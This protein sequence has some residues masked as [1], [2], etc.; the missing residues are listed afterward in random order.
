MALGGTGIAGMNG[1]VG[2][3]GDAADG[4]VEAPGTPVATSAH[5]P[6][7]GSDAAAPA[8]AALLQAR[9]AELEVRT[10]RKQ[11]LVTDQECTL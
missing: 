6:E 8:K 5:R 1:E 3:G 7:G 11:T 2:G 4:V 9:V 10:N